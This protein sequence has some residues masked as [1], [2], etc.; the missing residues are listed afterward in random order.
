[1][2][3]EYS[4]YSKTVQF[5]VQFIPCKLVNSYIRYETGYLNISFATIYYII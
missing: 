2:T 5:S 3:F 4:Y 1:M